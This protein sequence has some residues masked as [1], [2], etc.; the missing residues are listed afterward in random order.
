MPD[1]FIV[2]VH[3][4]FVEIF[5]IQTQIIKYSSQ[6]RRIGGLWGNLLYGAYNTGYH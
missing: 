5:D 1:E 6:K 4:V 2:I 3:F